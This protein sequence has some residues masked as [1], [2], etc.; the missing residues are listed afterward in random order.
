[1]RRNKRLT[2]TVEETTIMSEVVTSICHY[3]SFHSV[4]I[5]YTSHI[6]TSI[7]HHN[8]HPTFPFNNNTSQTS[9]ANPNCNPTQ[10]NATKE[11]EQKKKKREKRKKKKNSQSCPELSAPSSPS[12]PSTKLKPTGS[13]PAG[14]VVE[15][16]VITG[17]CVSN[18]RATSTSV[19]RV[20][21][22]RPVG[23]GEV[24]VMV[25]GIGIVMVMVMVMVMVGGGKVVVGV[26]GDGI[27][28]KLKRRGFVMREFRGGCD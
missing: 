6:A 11:K 15:D 5:P 1:M 9:G 21:R 7:Q 13:P 27:E 10:P 26:V 23:G 19:L 4:L 28:R 20:L 24:V 2:V 17:T 25:M 16:F 12:T 18:P 22:N 8:Q 3:R 14:T